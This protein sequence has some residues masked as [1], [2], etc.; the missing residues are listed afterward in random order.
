MTTEPSFGMG[1]VTRGHAPLG[2]AAHAECTIVF[3]GQGAQR[4]GMGA[5][6]CAEFPL[7]RDTF[8]E[9]GA[10]V[11]AD[12]LRICAERDP[13]LHRTEYTQPCVLTMEI[14]AYRVLV[15]ECGVRPVAFGGHSLGEY[16][17]L[18]AAGVFDL[19][20]GV[21]LVRT[22]GA[23]M[24]RA[25]PEGEGAMAALILPDIADSEVAELVAAAGAEVAND[26]S[27]DQLVISGAADVVAG[28]RAILA[29]RLPDLRF[30]PLRVSAPFH[31]RW[32]RGIEAEFAEHLA[33]CAQRTRADRAVA[34]TSNYTGEFH[35]PETLTENLVRQIAAPVRWTDNMRAL[36]RS[37]TR[38]Y[39]IGP[40][41]PL[42]KFFA[43]LNAPVTRIATVGDLRA[44][45]IEDTSPI[46]QAKHIAAPAISAP[47]TR[48]A[49]EPARAT[50]PSGETGVLT[51]HRRSAGTPI[52][53]LFCWPFA[54]GK[55][56]AYTPWRRRLPDWV[57]LCVIELPARQ[58]HL[59]QTPIRRFTDLVDAA[60]T[61]VLP[62][63][64]LPFAF[65]GH[66]LGALTA[67]EVA[68]GLPAG[69]APRALFLGGAAAPHLPRPG[70]LSGLPDHEFISAVGHY[71]G[72]P[73][74][75]RDT[76]EVM[77]LFLP[78]LRSDF[79]IFDDYRFAPAAAPSCPAHLFGGRDDRQVATTQLEAWR[80][81]LPGLRSTELLPGGHFFLVE[82]RAA[83][84]D[85]L[86]DKLTAVR[87]DVVPA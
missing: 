46:V 51:I 72:I 57:E 60:L 7:A 14:A 61:Q 64:D 15:A 71:G 11:G 16:A 2:M 85:S 83:L 76:P 1:A 5:D 12:L 44:L 52:L 62:L 3:P 22:R 28:A 41:A 19:A 70:R 13:R 37:G 79:E 40:S 20:D 58:R 73:P 67:Y 47:T 78:A 50:L 33:A 59:A 43:T 49:A 17:A 55:A 6:F 9:A 4:T 38:R 86:A 36:L 87:P 75:V 68:R 18:V 26:N 10:A 48:T 8:A 32:M 80:D 81:V 77:A 65:F 35:R 74:E 63:T 84:L 53:R 39:E 69:I 54:G 66:S 24:Q 56:A 34:V 29:E 45:P 21:R 23:L 31:S 82:H 42:S 30:V 25:V 27:T